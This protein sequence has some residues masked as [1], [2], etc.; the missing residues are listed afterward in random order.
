ELIASLGAEHVVDF[1]VADSVRLEDAE[2]GGLPGVTRIHREDGRT[3]LTVQRVHE[4]IP[5]LMALLAA[6]SAQLSELTTHHA[7]LEDVFMTLTG[8]HLRDG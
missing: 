4:T 1:A 3:R 2:L 7:T 5:A 6:R 8:R